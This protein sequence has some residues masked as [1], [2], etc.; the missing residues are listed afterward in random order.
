VDGAATEGDVKTAN[1]K[2]CALTALLLLMSSALAP[3]SIWA[4]TIASAVGLNGHVWN[5]NNEDGPAGVGQFISVFPKSGTGRFGYYTLSYYSPQAGEGGGI[6]GGMNEAGLTFDFNAIRK[7]KNFDPKTKKAFPHGD[8]A[9]LPHI[10]ATMDSV[11]DVMGFFETYWFQGGFDSAQMH[12]ADRHGRFAIISASGMQLTAPGKPLVSTNFDICGKEDGS[13]CKRYAKATAILSKR[14]A[15]LST[16]THLCKETQQGEGTLY[17][18]VQNL[19]TG[20]IWFSSRLDPGT[21]VRISLKELLSR[22]RR[23]YAFTDLRSL[24]E[25]RPARIWKE[26]AP[27]RVSDSVLDAYTGAFFNGFSGKLVVT[28]HNAG[29]KLSTGDGSFFLFR[30]ASENVFFHPKKDF[31]IKFSFDKK[32]NLVM[33]LYEDGFWSLSATKMPTTG[34]VN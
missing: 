21:N 20:D 29:I 15:D 11:D 28:R 16:M 12:V 24:R 6:Q 5:A 34:K 13:S 7:A 4:C 27:V 30:P 33:R 14:R 26:P 10:L 19:T 3:R 2:T 1:V 17:S 25:A 23:A 18:N 9:I 8:A 32:A 31:Q 22:G